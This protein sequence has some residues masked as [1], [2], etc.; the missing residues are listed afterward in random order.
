MKKYKF[1]HNIKLEKKFDLNDFDRNAI[2]MED[3]I[4]LHEKDMLSLTNLVFDMSNP[5]WEKKIRY[6]I[7]P[8]FDELYSNTWS[9]CNVDM[10]WSQE[11]LEK[12]AIFLSEHLNYLPHYI[13]E[14][15]YTIIGECL[16]YR[17]CNYKL[18]PSQEEAERKEYIELG[19]CHLTV[20][21]KLIMELGKLGIDCRAIR[22][23]PE[24]FY[25][26]SKV[27]DCFLERDCSEYDIEKNYIVWEDDWI[28]SRQISRV[29]CVHDLEEFITALLKNIS[30]LCRFS[31]K[32]INPET[33]DFSKYYYPND[34][35]PNSYNLPVGELIDVKTCLTSF[36]EQLKNGSFIQRYYDEKNVIDLKTVGVKEIFKPLFNVADLKALLDYLLN[37]GYIQFNQSKLCVVDEQLKDKL[38]DILHYYYRSKNTTSDYFSSEV[39]KNEINILIQFIMTIINTNTYVFNT[40]INEVDTKKETTID[41]L[42]AK[43]KAVEERQT[44]LEEKVDALSSDFDSL[45]EQI[46]NYLATG[47]NK[48]NISNANKE[49]VV[50]IIKNVQTQTLASKIRKGLLLGT[51]ALGMIGLLKSSTVQLSEFQKKHNSKLCNP[52]EIQDVIS[53]LAPDLQETME[54]LP[55]FEKVSMHMYEIDNGTRDYY[56]SIYDK[57][58]TG[59]TSQEGIIIRYFVL[60]EN[61]LIAEIGTEEELQEFI[62]NNNV[63]D[64]V[65]KSAISCLDYQVLSGY[66]EQGIKIPLQYTTFFADYTPSIGVS[67]IRENKNC[68]S[69]VK[70]K[71]KKYQFSLFQC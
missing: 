69:S 6:E 37:E 34:A 56:V 48:P 11:N 39:V 9:L 61:V 68:Y 70:S 50:S 10:G 12:G 64:F 5:I 36:L 14:S 7:N 43:V 51:I 46:T 62:E 19:K 52:I 55:T 35:L 38:P 27:S 41:E 8:E 28:L 13:I 16:G 18:Y 58:N 20:L 31:D 53:S 25:I 17:V 71:E 23:N 32:M 26:G 45:R 49:I 2:M 4:E 60:Q 1:L 42:I 30:I 33:I 15:T 65:W 47:K 24:I 66:I 3:I 59:I 63:N 40:F 67:R 57:E 22:I 54:I 29:L 21:M 44:N